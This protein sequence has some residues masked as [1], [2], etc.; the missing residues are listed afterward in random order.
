[1][2]SRLVVIVISIFISSCIAMEKKQVITMVELLSNSEKYAGKYVQISGVFAGNRSSGWHLFLDEGSYK[3]DVKI[4]SIVFRDQK[5]IDVSD[6]RFNEFEGKYITLV[7]RFEKSTSKKYQFSGVLSDTKYL[8][9]YPILN[10][11]K[12]DFNNIKE[13]EKNLKQDEVIELR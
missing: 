6:K 1:M 2:I 5:F 12:I 3:N 10:A 11:D 7:A 9:S 13:H 4:N 8:L